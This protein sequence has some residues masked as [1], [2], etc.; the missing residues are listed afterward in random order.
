MGHLSLKKVAFVLVLLFLGSASAYA[1]DPG[2]ERIVNWEASGDERSMLIETDK[3]TWYL[4]DFGLPCLGLR[5]AHSVGFGFRYM[6]EVDKGDTISVMGKR[7]TIRSVEPVD[8][9]AEA[10]P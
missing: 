1:Q 9:P 5:T 7:C 8:P 3:E 10:N 6:Q 4:I 2:L